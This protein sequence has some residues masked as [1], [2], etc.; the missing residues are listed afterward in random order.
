MQ[1]VASVEVVRGAYYL[2]TLRFLELDFRT[3]RKAENSSAIIG[4]TLD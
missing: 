3:A 2:R 1:G 4:G